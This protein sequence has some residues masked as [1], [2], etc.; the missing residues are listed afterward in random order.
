[1]RLPFVK[2]G[3]TISFNDIDIQHSVRIRHFI[4]K[5]LGFDSHS[6]AMLITIGLFI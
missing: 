2:K 3:L 1:M 6:C 4:I 5:A